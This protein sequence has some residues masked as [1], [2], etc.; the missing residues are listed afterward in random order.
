[1][2]GYKTHLGGGIICFVSGIAVTYIIG[3]YNPDLFTSMCW[4]FATLFGSLFP[5][6]DTKSKVQRF[7]Y[8]CLFVV[9]LYLLCINKMTLFALLSLVALLP[10]LVNHRTIFHRPLFIFLLSGVFCSL[11]LYYEPT[12]FFM[13][14]TGSLF[15]F[16]GCI[17]HIALDK[18]PG[19]V[20][21]L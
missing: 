18:G 12:L 21:K 13:A 6:I 7:V 2:P 17:T 16:F 14:Y 5:D 15:F 19:A 8:I 1:M 10:L 4:F 3:Q 9:S 11:I 20:F